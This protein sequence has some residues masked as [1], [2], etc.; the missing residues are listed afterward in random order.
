M[1]LQVS[2]RARRGAIAVFTAFVLVALVAI[3]GLFLSLSYIELTRTE[4]Q[5]ATD[6]AARSAVVRLVAEQSETQGRAA[7]VEIAATY[8]VGGVPFAIDG[9]Q[10][11]IGNASRGFG[12]G[13]TFAPGV[14]PL[15]AVRVTGL[16]SA[17]SPAGEVELPFGNFVGRSTHSL[18]TMATAMRLD[19]DVCLVLDRSGSMAWDLTDAQ[20]SYPGEYGQRPILE[21]YFSPPH[22]TQSRWAVLASAVGE[23]VDIFQQRDVSAKVGLVTFASDYQFG[24]FRSQRV[25]RDQDLTE[26]MNDVT[27]RIQVIGQSPVVG[28]TDIT[29]GL[30]EAESM[31]TTSPEARLR[32]GQPIIVLFSDGMF[33]EGA[34]PVVTAAELYQS[35]QIVIHSVTFG[36]DEA[37]RDTMDRVANVAGHGLSLH[38]NT[39]AELVDSFRTIAEA[40]PVL[41]TE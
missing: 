28:A 8:R 40:I 17:A 36:A 10:V 12:G 37:A 3:A 25:T 31:L 14:S 21:N 6:A 35:H 1:S 16:K 20:F 32:T 29:A 15:N 30:L 24:K 22:A 27:N 5:A 26:S 7:A 34:D 19:Y 2:R 18:D 13:F 11:Q 23:L 38:A 33:T 9:S 4:L 41:I 39:A